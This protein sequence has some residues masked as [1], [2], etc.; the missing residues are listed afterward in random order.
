MEIFF[1][2]QAGTTDRLSH[3]NSNSLLGYP[4][5]IFDV[6]LFIITKYMLKFGLMLY[7]IDNIYK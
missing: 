7:E 3:T 2:I 1:I 4:D 5:Q 6:L